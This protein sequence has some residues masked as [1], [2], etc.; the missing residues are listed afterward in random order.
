MTVDSP[1]S[2]G[3]DSVPDS[4]EPHIAEAAAEPKLS[5][6]ERKLENKSA[7]ARAKAKRRPRRSIGYWAMRG[8]R[9][10]WM[11]LVILVVV[12]VG[13]F[14]VDRLH[15][16]FGKTE[17]TRP[18]S[19][20]AND[21][22][23]FNP[24][25]V[26]YEIYGPPG[27]C[28]HDQLP[29]PRRRAADRPR[30][31]PALVA[32]PDHHRSGGRG[33]HRRPGRQRH[34]R[35]PDH[36]RRRPQGREDRPPESTRRPSAWSSPHDHP[37]Q[38]PILPTGNVRCGRAPTLGWRTG[39]AGSRCPSSWSGWRWPCSPTSPCRR[40]RWWARSSPCRWRPRTRRR[41]SR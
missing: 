13:A 35:L 16:V 20:L 41:P 34:H 5:R 25:T 18:G 22:K 23:P 28:C 36:R 39:S 12:V 14:G 21:T 30:R 32:H 33:Q 3:S 24:K 8:L 9:K 10:A 26:V 1:A 37:G 29:R 17:T 6:R 19:G 40:S 38:A 4:L 11:P 7:K 27:R 31:H 2:A 15:G